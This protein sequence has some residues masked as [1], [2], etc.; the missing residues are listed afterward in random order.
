MRLIIMIR[1]DVGSRGD[2]GMMEDNSQNQ[3]DWSYCLDFVSNERRSDAFVRMRARVSVMVRKWLKR[4]IPRRLTSPVCM[5][6][7][8]F[9]KDTQFILSQRRSHCACLDWHQQQSL[10]SDLLDSQGN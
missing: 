5:T 1:E 7:L 4:E 10:V 9:S 8:S 6:C 3:S 2:S